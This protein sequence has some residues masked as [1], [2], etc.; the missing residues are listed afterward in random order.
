MR[1]RCSSSSSGG[2]GGHQLIL[3]WLVIACSWVAVARAQAQKPAGAT[4]DPV[5]GMYI[6]IYQLITCIHRLQ[7]HRCSFLLERCSWR[8]DI[9]F[10]GCTQACSSLLSIFF[11]T[12]EFRE[13]WLM[14]YDYYMLDDASLFVVASTMG[15]VDATCNR[16][17]LKL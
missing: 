6:C 9:D 16:L 10:H 3:C 13:T 12:S 5:E 2:H 8:K 14:S 1:I 15:T 4:T 17:Q 7:R 11:E